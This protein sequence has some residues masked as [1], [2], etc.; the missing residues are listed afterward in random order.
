MFFRLSRRYTAKSAWRCARL[1]ARRLVL[2]SPAGGLGIGV[3]GGEIRVG[4]VGGELRK[5]QS[6]N[7][8]KRLSRG[9]RRWEV[10]SHLMVQFY[11]KGCNFGIFPE[12]PA[13][14]Y[15]HF[16][17]L[18]PTAQFPASGKALSVELNA[19]GPPPRLQIR[20]EA[21]F[22]SN[23]CPFPLREGQAKFIR[24]PPLARLS[25]GRLLARSKGNE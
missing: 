10:F 11:S 24:T 3:L 1:W 7:R 17:F 16:L 22:S 2:A 8:D 18:F 25:N 9:S 19:R 23:F 21:G 15:A 5:F 6:L 14:K 4:D 20:Q 12:I 13:A